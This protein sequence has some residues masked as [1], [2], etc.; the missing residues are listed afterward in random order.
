MK[1]Y[2]NRHAEYIISEGKFR[3]CESDMKKAEESPLKRGNEKRLKNLEKNM[4][5]VSSFVDSFFPLSKK[6]TKNGIE[7][8]TA[9]IV[10]TF[11]I[12]Y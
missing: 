5:K 1:H 11:F 6:C 8:F 12:K 4:D 10:E 3:A 2:Y 7:V 9:V